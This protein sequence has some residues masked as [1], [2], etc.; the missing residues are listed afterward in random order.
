MNHSQNLNDLFMDVISAF[1]GCKFPNLE[2]YQEQISQL[3]SK[4]SD[5]HKFAGNSHVSVLLT[6]FLRY[7][8]FFKKISGGK[9]PKFY[10]FT[11]FLK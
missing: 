6:I 11:I 9:R 2:I 4:N 8:F 5:V 1:S 10:Y 3:T 7:I